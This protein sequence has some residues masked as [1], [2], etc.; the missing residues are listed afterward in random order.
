[1]F[2]TARSFPLWFNNWQDSAW[3]PSWICLSLCWSSLF[4]F[5]ATLSLTI[6]SLKWSSLSDSFFI[7]QVKHC[8]FMLFYVDAAIKPKNARKIQG[9]IQDKLRWFAKLTNSKYVYMI[10]INKRTKAKWQKQKK[11]KKGNRV[12]IYKSAF[13][14]I[15]NII[16]IPIICFAVI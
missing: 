10:K 15:N 14:T 16:F 4:P 3:L 2:V 11:K 8:R 12:N 7:M 6:I 13:N 9:V 1:M 5:S